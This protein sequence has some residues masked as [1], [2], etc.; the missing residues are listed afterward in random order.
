MVS[1]EEIQSTLYGGALANR[2][3]LAT[4]LAGRA[5]ARHT[6]CFQML[7]AVLLCMHPGVLR[8]G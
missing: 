7:K 4:S 6:V 8:S 2:E 3:D 5:R 1:L